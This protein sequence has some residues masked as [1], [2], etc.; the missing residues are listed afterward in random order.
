MAI[1]EKIRGHESRQCEIKYGKI[2]IYLKKNKGNSQDLLEFGGTFSIVE[3]V[4]AI[5]Y[6]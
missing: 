4:L 2:M 5:L 1:E 6:D 3:V